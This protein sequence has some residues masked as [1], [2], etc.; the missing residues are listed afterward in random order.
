VI[1][2]GYPDVSQVILSKE[3]MDGIINDK[4]K[5]NE[6]KGYRAF[7][8]T[9]CLFILMKYLENYGFYKPSLLIL[10]SPILSLK[11]NIEDS[12]HATISMK[13]LLFKYIIE[14]CG[15]NQ[16][17]IAENDIPEEIDYSNTNLISF[18]KENNEGR[19]G[20]LYQQD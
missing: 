10:D 9:I 16:I 20:F 4:D 8:N 19:Y 14:Q 6:G 11:E 1:R 5:K 7:L 3:T 13:S 15:N 2:C 18:T 17:I 12:E